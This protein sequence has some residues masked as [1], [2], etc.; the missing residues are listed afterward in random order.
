MIVPGSRA[1]LVRGAPVSLTMDASRVALRIQ[2]SPP[3]Q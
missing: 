1:Q 3:K 2:V